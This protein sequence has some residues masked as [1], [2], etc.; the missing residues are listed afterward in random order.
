MRLSLLAPVLG[1]ALLTNSLA[2]Q[3][4]QVKA[5]RD[6]SLAVERAA[7]AQPFRRMLLKYAS[8]GREIPEVRVVASLLGDHE[9]AEFARAL[10]DSVQQV[11][12]ARSAVYQ[13][14][15]TVDFNSPTK[16]TVRVRV[17]T[18]SAACPEHRWTIGVLIIDG[19]WRSN[20]MTREM[21]GKC[22]I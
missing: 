19:Q 11:V 15:T 5:S 6:D 16:A 17:R 13:L 18:P 10:R 3:A 21:L 20:V 4:P 12:G 22:A 2:A 7:L 14:S 8:W 1:T 9:R